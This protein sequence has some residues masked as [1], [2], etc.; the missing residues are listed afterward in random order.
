MS[1]CFWALQIYKVLC[2]M[3][4]D[5]IGPWAILHHKTGHNLLTKLFSKCFAHENHPNVLKSLGHRPQ[6]RVILILS[7]GLDIL[8]FFCFVYSADWMI[9]L[10]CAICGLAPVPGPKIY[11]LHSPYRLS[12]QL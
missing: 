8:T 6:P 9:T 7:N 3:G 5:W 1:G 11:F 4:S 12:I 10:P 2:H